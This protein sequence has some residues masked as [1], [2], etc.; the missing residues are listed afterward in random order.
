MSC[1][2]PEDERSALCLSGGETKLLVWFQKVKQVTCCLWRLNK[3]AVSKNKFKIWTSIEWATIAL[4]ANIEHGDAKLEIENNLETNQAG[5]QESVR[6][7]A[8]G[9][10]T[11][12]LENENKAQQ[13]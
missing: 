2:I 8:V 13:I 4:R 1:F 11:S 7:A 6:N 9:A 10:L 5:A 3:V 12:K